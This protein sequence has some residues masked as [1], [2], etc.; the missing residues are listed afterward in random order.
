VRALLLAIIAAALPSLAAAQELAVPGRLDL[1]GLWELTEYGA[2]LGDERAIVRITHTGPSV[3]AEFVSGARCWDGQAR[4]DA[5]LAELRVVPPTTTG[6]LSSPA[7]WVCSGSP[8]AVKKCGGSGAVK[9]S[10]KTTFTDADVEPNYIE[11]QRVRQ[12]YQ[13][14]S[15]DPSQDG[16]AD[17]SLRRLAPCEFEQLMV[18]Q[19]ESELRVVMM[20]IFG[21]R[22]IF[23]VAYEAARQRYPETFN[24]LPTEVLGRPY[25]MIAQ[26]EEPVFFFEE[27]LPAVIGSPDWIG[28]RTMAAD[29]GLQEANPVLA[30]REML[31]QMNRIEDEKAPEGQ[32]ALAALRQA[33]AQLEKCRRAQP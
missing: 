26:D 23:R 21:A 27:W 20:S 30:V 14:C 28:A 15:L 16:T 9:P 12:G 4:P 7:M 32:R 25:E 10:Y 22:A 24:G 17:F 31:I 18:D 8:E 11:G 1:N 2:R 5:F 13:D 19:R 6:L 33:R 3:H 29:M